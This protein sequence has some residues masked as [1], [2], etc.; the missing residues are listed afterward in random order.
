MIVRARKRGLL[1]AAALAAGLLVATVGV[2]LGCDDPCVINTQ[3]CD[4]YSAWSTTVCCRDSDGDGIYHCISCD[5]H[6]F[7]CWNWG[8]SYMIRGN[9]FNCYDP[10]EQ[11]AEL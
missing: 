4:P 1:T 8:M 9:P 2:A 10:G 6:H 11:C 5:R 3:G 7:L